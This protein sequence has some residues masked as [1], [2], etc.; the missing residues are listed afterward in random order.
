M[1]VAVTET[2]SSIFGGINELVVPRGYLSDSALSDTATYTGQTFSSLGA[3]PGK[4]K[5]TWGK[6]ANQKF[7]ARNRH[8]C[9]RTLH[10]GD[11]GCSA[12]ACSASSAIA[13]HA[14][15]TLWRKQAG[16]PSRRQH[17]RDALR[18]T[19]RCGTSFARARRTPAFCWAKRRLLGACEGNEPPF[20]T[21][22][23][24]CSERSEHPK[25]SRASEPIRAACRPA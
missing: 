5:W 4:Y 15:T 8:C 18:R 20:V 3:T 17:R 7:H 1:P 21:P 9:P 10:L 6:G 25:P 19:A 16:P 11:D 13:R 12:S 24:G 14:A 2:P 23:K 22:R